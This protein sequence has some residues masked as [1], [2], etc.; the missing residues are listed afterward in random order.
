MILAS[1]FKAAKLALCGANGSTKPASALRF[2]AIIG[3]AAIFVIVPI[4]GRAAYPD[5]PIQITISFPPAGATDVLARAVGNQLA[6][7]LDQSVIIENRAGAGGAIGLVA[8]A[9]AAPNGYNL[10][11]AATTNQAIAAAIYKDQAASLVDDFV[12]IG[13]IGFVPHALVVP[14]SLPVNN[15]QE[16]IAYI[17]KSPGHYNYASQG[18]GTL[19]HLEGDLFKVQ[20][21]LDITHVPYK[22]SVQALPD[23]VNGLAVMMFDSVTGSMPLVKGNKLRFL[24]VASSERVSLLPNIPT[25]K[26]AGIENV[27]ADNLFGLFAPKD[28]PQEVIH[29]L[30][31][32]LERAL[33]NPQLVSTM[34]AQGAEL[35]FGPAPELANVIAD[36]H[37]FWGDVVKRADIEA[38]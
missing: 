38:Q 17:K 36:E 33:K 14:A 15:V 29:T 28:T 25:L 19:S 34:A 4:E 37:S 32:A 26:E 1:W 5:K 30:S 12:P 7:E 23:V 9:R 24:A 2:C 11:L 35:R 8:G 21:D 20:N 16:L 27:V 13:L 18:V 31:T 3:A 10:Y 6:K 22:G